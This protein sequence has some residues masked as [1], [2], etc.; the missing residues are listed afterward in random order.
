MPEKKLLDLFHQHNVPYQLYEH[1]AA[2]TSEQADR[3]CRLVPGTHGKNLFLRDEKKKF[4]L[5]STF[6]NKR[7]DLKAL[8]KCCGAGRFSF[9]NPADLL[10]KLGVMPGSVTPYGLIHDHNHE[11]TFLL[12]QDFLMQE[13]VN[14]HPLRNDMTI[15]MQLQ[16]F[17]NFFEIIKRNPRMITVPV[18]I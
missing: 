3:V 5:L 7:V 17:L 10:A 11:V 12:D 6:P 16:N 2:F 8:S 1:E 13:K 15:G 4:F 9:G 14:F 18:L